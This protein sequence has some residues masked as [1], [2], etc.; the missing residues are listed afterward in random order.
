MTAFKKGVENMK[1]CFIINPNAG[2]GSFT[3][4]AQEN[5][6]KVCEQKKASYDIYLS[7]SVEATKEYIA[8]VA[9]NEDGAI[10]YACGGDGTIC[11]T[12][13]AIMALPEDKRANVALG[14]IPMGTGN[15][16]VSNFENKQLFFDIE[17]QLE[18]TPCRIDLFKCNDLYSVNMVNVG[19]DS[20]VVCKKEKIGK[21]AWVPRK[22]AYIFSLVITLVRKPGV[23]MSFCAEQGESVNKDLLLATFGNGAYCGGGFYSNPKASLFDGEIDCISV[24]NMGRLRFVS[25]V[26]KYKKG[27]HLDEKFK[28]IIENFKCREAHICLEE[29]TPVSIDGEIALLRE[30]HISVEREALTVMLPNGVTAKG[31]DKSNESAEVR[32]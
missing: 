29:E 4:E 9:S 27:L 18:S 6:Y 3:K 14:I 1:H 12:V 17:A 28:D 16:F 32:A 23:K 10:V 25:L 2:K 11:K 20:H 19:F 7:E 30:M 24:K 26:S 31:L 15:D 8:K 5:I 22:L 13:A 21:K